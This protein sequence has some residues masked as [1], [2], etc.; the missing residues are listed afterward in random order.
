MRYLTILVFLVLV[1]ASEEE[2]TER[3]STSSL[4]ERLP[5]QQCVT[6]SPCHQCTHQNETEPACKST[7][8]IY[9][10]VCNRTIYEGNVK[11]TNLEL[12]TAACRK[13]TEIIQTDI[14][15]WTMSACFYGVALFCTLLIVLDRRTRSTRGYRRVRSNS[16]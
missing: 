5:F 13:P 14:P 16:I 6:T 11:Q 8:Y 12:Y 9:E 1:M 10:Y 7:G 2:P 3:V 4:L 15:L